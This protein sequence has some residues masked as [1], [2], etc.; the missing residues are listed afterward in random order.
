MVAV[1]M[2]AACASSH[3]VAKDYHLEEVD[4][5]AHVATDSVR[6][7]VS[8]QDSVVKSSGVSYSV[9]SDVQE[10]EDSEETITEHITEQ[11]DAQGN[12][13]TT[14]D[15]TTKRK[16]SS[17]KQA[18]YDEQLRYQQHEIEQMKQSIDSLSTSNKSDVGTHW[19]KNDSS[20]QEKDKDADAVSKAASSWWCRFKEQIK[21]FAFGFVMFVVF[22][23]VGKYRKKH[24]EQEKK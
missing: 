19:A 8:V 21:A 3:R 4:S 7:T 20:Y 5:V 24:Y 23:L 15:R 22:F 12:K 2:L 6:K 9:K 10:R 13:I 17:S 1:M 18:N 16:G 11:T 14:T